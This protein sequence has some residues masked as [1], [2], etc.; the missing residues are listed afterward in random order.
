[1]KNKIDKNIDLL[2]QKTKDIPTEIPLKELKNMIL[3]FPDQPSLTTESY[4]FK[5]LF[6][7]KYIAKH[8][9]K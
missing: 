2:F 7:L 4:W 1:M 8:F 9:L 5:K 3:G 6:N